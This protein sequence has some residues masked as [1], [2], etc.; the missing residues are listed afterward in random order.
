MGKRVLALVAHPDDIEFHMAGT[1]LHLHAAG[2]ELHYCTVA[3]GSCGTVSLDRDDIV[4]IRTAESAAAAAALGAAYHKPFVDDLQIFYEAPLLAQVGALFRRVAPEILLTHSPEDYMEDHQNCCRLAVTAAFGRGMRNFQVSPE[5]PPMVG[6]VT[7]Y[8]AQPH[9]NLDP[10]GRRV[11]PDLFVDV[12]PVRE[13]K[14]A[15]LNCHRSQ[16]E[17]LDRS[18]GMGSYVQEMERLNAEVGALSGRY[19]L[20]EGWRRH[21]HLG[22]CGP[23]EDPLAVALGPEHCLARANS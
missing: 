10:L 17:W 13:K 20:S 1:L 5:T 3:N 9:G 6:S 4:R 21:L 2:Y 7:V 18:Q 11:V 23:S 14:R 22:L 16:A 12:E 8:H 15:L 19:L